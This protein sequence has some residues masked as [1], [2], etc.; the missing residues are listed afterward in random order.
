[1]YLFPS[2]V[3]LIST[4]RTIKGGSSLGG[5]YNFN[6]ALHVNDNEKDVVTNRSILVDYYD[7]PSDPA[8]LNQT[9]LFDLL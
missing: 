3:K 5:F 9:P 6:L 2:N 8:W 7:L 1:M 4:Q